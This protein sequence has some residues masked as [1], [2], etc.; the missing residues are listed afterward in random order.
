MASTNSHI[1]PNTLH[2]FTASSDGIPSLGVHPAAV[3]VPQSNNPFTGGA[4][5]EI[6]T[7]HTIKPSV[8]ADDPPANITSDLKAKEAKAHSAATPSTFSSGTTGT[9]STTS[10]KPTGTSASSDTPLATGLRQRV[11]NLGTQ[12]EHAQ[13][14]PAVQNVK[15]TAQKQVGQFREFL[16]RSKTVRS[17][18]QRFNVDRVVLVTGAV[19]A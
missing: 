18:E 5:S 19:L 13:D 4:P 15:G 9:T 17:L 14:H 7:S 1:D 12:L 3:P 11:N 10:S 8:V 16:G 2:Q 6:D